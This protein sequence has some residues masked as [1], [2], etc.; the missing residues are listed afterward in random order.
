MLYYCTL[1]LLNH[2]EYSVRDYALHAVSKLLPHTDERLFKLSETFLFQNLKIARDE[3]IMRSYLMALRSIVVH[4]QTFNFKCSA[5][6]LVPLLNEEHEDFFV[7]ILSMQL[8]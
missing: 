1:S 3:M 5:Q 6:D 7:Q 8:A 4:S 2:Q